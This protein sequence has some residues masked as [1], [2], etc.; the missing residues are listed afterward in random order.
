MKKKIRL[1]SGILTLFLAIAVLLFINRFQKD[2]RIEK[3]QDSEIAEIVLEE[4]LPKKLIFGF[5][6][7]SFYVYQS[8]IER[9]EF[10]STILLKHHVD[11]AT[12]DQLSKKSKAIFDVRKIRAGKQYTILANKD[13]LQKAAYFIYQPNAVDYIVYQL[14]D[15]ISIIKA[16]KEV[17]TK[18]EIS[19][20]IIQSSL[21]ESLKRSNNDASLAIALSEI[22]AWSIDFYRIQKGDWYKVIYEKQYV[23]EQAIGIGRILA[24]EFKHFDKNFLGF[25]F[26]HGENADYFDEEANSLRKAFLKSPLKFSRLSSRYT[27]RRFHPV[28]KRWK[29]HL[30]TDYAAPTGTPIMSTGDGHVTKASYTGGNGNYVKVRH[31]SVYETQYLHMS[32]RNVSVGQFVKQGDII[33]YVGSTGLATGPHVCYRFWKNGKQVDHLNQDFPSAE[34]VAPEYKDLFMKQIQ[35]YKEKLNQIDLPEKLEA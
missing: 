2:Q 7:D 3:E 35:E 31:N 11:Y 15:S 17:E 9:N 19:S 10:L 25:Y 16:E 13:S 5:P 24:V 6:E 26:E 34:P 33:G 21:Y 23:D 29:A 1:I 8:K 22:F 14:T 4:P 30:G 32:K 20:G 12:I 28:Q 18:I 27:N